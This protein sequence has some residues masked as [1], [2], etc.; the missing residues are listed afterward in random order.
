M[1]KV[2]LTVLF[3]AVCSGAFAQSISDRT[4]AERT[5]DMQRNERSLANNPYTQRNALGMGAEVLYGTEIES[6][7]LGLKF[8]WMMTDAFRLEPNVG[9][10]FKNDGQS[11]FDF[12][13]DVHYM[14]KISNRW[15]FYPIA[16][17]TLSYWDVDH[18]GSDTNF[19]VNL[20]AGI[21]ADI[22]QHWYL[23]F[24]FKYRLISDYDQAVLGLGVGYRF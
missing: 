1:K 18:Y 17:L 2:V 16:G 13:V 12:N 6:V 8:N 23:D 20:G 24:S 21:E 14:V 3:A 19:G 15:R 4:P 9:I 10:W 11:S 5:R 22:N 7:G